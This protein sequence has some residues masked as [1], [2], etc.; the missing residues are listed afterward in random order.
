VKDVTINV[1]KSDKGYRVIVV[2]DAKTVD[3]SNERKSN[4]SE[5]NPTSKDQM[6]LDVNKILSTI[7]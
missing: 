6:I 4:V 3:N 7:E 2:D 1:A 5:L